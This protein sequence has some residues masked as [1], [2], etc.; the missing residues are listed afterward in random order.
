MKEL[1]RAVKELGLKA[2]KFNGGWGDGDLDNEVLFPLYEEI[3]DLEYS[4]PAAS[5]GARLRIAA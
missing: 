2:V 1:R 3:A 5:G 4:D